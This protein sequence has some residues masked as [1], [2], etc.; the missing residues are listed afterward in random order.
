MKQGISPLRNQADWTLNLTQQ[1]L[2]RK[3][4]VHNKQAG[5]VVTVQPAHIRFLY[6]VACPQVQIQ[7]KT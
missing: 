6:S 3:R 2:I 4:L 5:I 7:T 1:I